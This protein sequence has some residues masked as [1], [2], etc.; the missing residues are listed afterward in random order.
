MRFL[1]LVV[2]LMAGIFANDT[3]AAQLIA[4]TGASP[5][6]L[7]DLARLVSL[8][9]F[10]ATL[11]TGALTLLDW[12]KRKDPD[13]KTPRIAELLSQRNSMLDDMLFI[14]GNLETGHRTT[15]RTGLPTVYWRLL[16]QGVPPSKSTTAQVDEQSGMLEAWSEVDKDLATL[17]GN[18]NSFRLSESKAFIEAMNQEA[19]Q[20]LI[21]GNSGIAGEEFTGFAPRYSAISGAQ[22]AENII[23]AGGT[24]SD[25][26]SIWLVGWS[27]RSVFG[28]FPKGSKAGLTREDLGVQH[29]TLDASSNPYSAHVDKFTWDAGLCVRD[30]RYIVR[31]ANIDVS[32][33]IGESSAA[34]IM[35]LMT[36]AVH[37]TP[38]GTSARYAWYCNNTAL[39]MLDVQA[40][41]KANVYLTVGQEE[42]QAKLSFRG[43][44]IRR[45]DQLTLTEAQ[46][47]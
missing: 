18:V 23:D 35:K 41:N 16:N 32:N 9:V 39:T 14:E 45:C 17:G 11:S 33:L 22:N 2:A 38:P 27:P 15:I 4:H 20:T 42:G 6:L 43:I 37:K 19:A 21:Y 12:A 47:T 36:K 46:V 44:P 31:I 13:G 26:T 3:Q 29:L 30:W 34:D 25:N 5:S 1:L 28:I 40:Q 7:T 24:G 10:G 8:A